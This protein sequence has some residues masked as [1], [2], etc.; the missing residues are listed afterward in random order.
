MFWEVLTPGGS[1]Q[2]GPQG[3]YWPDLCRLPTKNCYILNIQAL[4]LVVAERKI[5]PCFPLYEP[6]A[7]DIPGLGQF[8]TQGHAWQDF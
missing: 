2:Y 5:F 7:D 4:V 1:S 3:H 8:Q 6:K